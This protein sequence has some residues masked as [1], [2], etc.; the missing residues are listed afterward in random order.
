M[1][2]TNFFQDLNKILKKSSEYSPE[3]LKIL[4][5][6][7]GEIPKIYDILSNQN[8]E[9][10]IAQFIKNQSI[11]KENKSKP[12]LKIKELIALSAAVA[13]KCEYCQQVHIKAALELGAT[14]DQ[15]FETILISGMIAE[16]STLAVGLRE[17]EK[18]K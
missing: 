14:K 16:S 4:K 3:I 2:K 6:L 5:Q 17:F 7:Y 12:P 18:I 15:V 13:L 11:T 1:S 8:S 9:M 10:V